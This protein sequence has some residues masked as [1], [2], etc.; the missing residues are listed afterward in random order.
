MTDRRRAGWALFGATACST[1]LFG[2]AC[3]SSHGDGP[4]MT[5]SEGGTPAAGD[6]AAACVT[7]GLQV[8]TFAPGMKKSGSAGL[9]TFVLVSADPSPP[10]DPQLN[11]W[12]IQV[13]D[14]N[15][16]P[17]ND[18]A[19]SLPVGTPEWSHPKNPWMPNMKHGA[20][21]D[22]P[23]VT[24]NG[25]GTAKV[26]IYFTMTGLW[27]TYVVAQSGQTTDSTIF[28]FCLP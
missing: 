9:F 17:V 1:A 15:G 16:A 27:E 4:G 11:T 8:D 5:S 19:V 10:N 18:V 12:T 28:S 2:T 7:L 3:S 23:P 24:N 6:G 22:N 25:D 26:P 20:T 13:L 21:A 14:K